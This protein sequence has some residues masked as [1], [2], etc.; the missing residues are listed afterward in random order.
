MGSRWFEM[1]WISGLWDRRRG[2]DTADIILLAI[3]Q[4]MLRTLESPKRNC[5]SHS[6][7]ECSCRFLPT[8]LPSMVCARA[9][10]GPTMWPQPGW[11]RTR[12][13]SA[14]PGK[15]RYPGQGRRESVLHCLP[16][17]EAFLGTTSPPASKE[18]IL[19][20]PTDVKV[21]P[22]GQQDMV[23]CKNALHM[24]AAKWEQSSPH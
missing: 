15:S 19:A 12:F 10:C 7:Q 14:Y 4:V 21:A 18:T 1:N 3:R 16:A 20:V 6:L 23:A 8:P 9:L 2:S 5:Y 22:C 11:R 17:L 13:N 24:L